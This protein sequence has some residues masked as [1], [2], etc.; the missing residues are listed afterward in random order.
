[1]SEKNPLGRRAAQLA[2]FTVG[3]GI[4]LTFALAGSAS[5]DEVTVQDADVTNAGVG[6]AN[7]GGNVAVGNA[8][9]NT[10]AC[11]QGAVGVVASNSCDASNTSDGSASIETGDATGVGNQSATSV[12]QSK[13][14]S[15]DPGLVVTVQD[16]DVTNAG[17]GIGNSGLNAAVGNASQ[18][19]AVCAQGAVGVVASNS[20]D[21]SN[22]SDGTASI[23]TGDATGVGNQ[24][25][26]GVHQHAA[27]GDGA[28]LALIVQDADVTNVGVGLAN[29]GGNLAVGNASQNLAVNLQGAFGVLAS[30]TASVS[31]ASNGSASIKTGKA[32]GIGNSS[33]TD[34]SQ[35]ADV[36]PDGLAV[37]LQSAPVLN[38]GFG[39]ANSGLNAAVANG[40]LNAA[41]VAQVSFGLLASNVADVDSWSDGFAMVLTGDATGIG[42]QSVTAV[43]QDA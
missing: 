42:N 40:S 14:G 35:G 11:A 30:N 3:G 25:A 31:N 41:I 6:V 2:A 43:K 9:Q 1:M 19:A 22:T 13:Q 5:A 21:V 38:A 15:S 34:I 26:T 4:A 18:N 23:E 33:A 17:V 12:E 27:S 32:T 20:C 8:S 7:S 36:D 39:A 10:A 28:G 16:S 24:S 29:S 37:V